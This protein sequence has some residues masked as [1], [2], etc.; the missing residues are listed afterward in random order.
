[1]PLSGLKYYGGKSANAGSQ[2]GAWVASLLPYAKKSCYV[3]PFGGM[4]G[5]LLQ[6]PPASVEIANDI[7]GH[8]IH[9]W[10]S[11]RDY[12]EEFAD[13][14]YWT[15]QSRDVFES[16]RDLLFAGKLKGLPRALAVH[17]TLTQSFNATL[18]PR[19]T[20]AVRYVYDTGPAARVNP[21]EQF[22]KL[23]DRICNVR[24]ENMCALQ[25]IDRVR[26]LPEA[27]LYLDPPYEGSTIHHYAEHQVDFDA[28]RDLLKQPDNRAR[29]AI[30]S[31]GQSY[32]C[33][34]W[35]RHEK[36]VQTPATNGAEHIDKSR[37]E[38]LWTNY[39]TDS[40]TRPLFAALNIST[41][42]S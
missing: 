11:V 39:K 1:M 7:H 41:I 33:L 9:W 15:P 38:V 10:L 42:E 29:I 25:L 26:L 22:Q 30:S 8:L 12:T 21:R 36:K 20:W 31:Y 32:D 4:L 3:E 13:L 34:D 40:L 16:L 18:N 24:F 23:R 14:V 17:V 6:R 19:S 35:V 28:L 5:V 2:T 37:T 27:V